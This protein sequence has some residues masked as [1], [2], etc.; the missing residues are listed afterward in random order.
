MTMNDTNDHDDRLEALEER[1]E[2][3]DDALAS[4]ARFT[5]R[6]LHDDPPLAGDLEALR[7]D[8]ERVRMTQLLLLQFLAEDLEQSRDRLAERLRD[9]DDPNGEASTR[10]ATSPGYY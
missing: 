6:Q 2:H 5:D 7:D 10:D 4:V 1:I 8:V 3:V 9:A